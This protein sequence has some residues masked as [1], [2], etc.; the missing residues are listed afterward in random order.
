MY[1]FEERFHNSRGICS[2]KN[3]EIQIMGGIVSVEC[4]FN[5][6]RNFRLQSNVGSTH[7]TGAIVSLTT[8]LENVN[9][10]FLQNLIKTI[11]VGGRI[12]SIQFIKSE[13]R[14]SDFKCFWA[15]PDN[16]ANLFFSGNV[17]SGIQNYRKELVKIIEKN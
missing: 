11:I 7:D 17:L 10:I 6:L 3:N 14:F 13:E 1:R 4:I 15:A 9:I 2:I 16:N 12:L 8:A 5:S